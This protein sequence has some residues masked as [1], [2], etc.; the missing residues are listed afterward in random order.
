MEREKKLVFMEGDSV[1]KYM[2]LLGIFGEFWKLEMYKRKGW[3]LYNDSVLC[4]SFYLLKR[5]NK[6]E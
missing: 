5:L 6:L 3:D 1:R 4:D 2:I